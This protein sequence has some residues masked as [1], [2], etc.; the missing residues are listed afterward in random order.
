METLELL[1]L[2]NLVIRPSCRRLGL[3]TE[4]T[5]AVWLLAA[6]LGK[7]GMGVFCIQDSLG[8]GVYTKAGLEACGYVLEF[9]KPV[10]PRQ[11]A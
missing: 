10:S 1:R 5:K 9:S 11:R 8:A 7:S 3:G 2:K 4:T 6:T